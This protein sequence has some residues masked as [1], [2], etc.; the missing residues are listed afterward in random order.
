MATFNSNEEFFSALRTLIEKWCDR[1]CLKALH[2]ILGAYLAFNGLIDGWGELHI[3]LQDVRAFART[4]LQ[5]DEPERLDDLIRAAD[6]ASH[7]AP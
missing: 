3:A 6:D 5:A 2:S 7:S 1:R 4:E